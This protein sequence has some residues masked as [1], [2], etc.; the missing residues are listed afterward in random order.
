VAVLPILDPDTDAPD[1]PAAALRLEL[2]TSLV[3]LPGLEV[4]DVDD[5]GAA[6]DVRG[7]SARYVLECGVQRAQGRLRVWALL[8]DTPTVNQIWGERWDGTT[9]DLFELTERVAQDIVRA[10]EVELVIGEPARLYRSLV[11]PASVERIYRGWHQLAK[12]TSTGLLNAIE[13]FETVSVTVPDTA[14]GPALTAFACWYGAMTGLSDDPEA[15]LARA[16]RD[17]ITGVTL[18]DDTGLS[19]MVKAALMLSEGGDLDEALEEARRAQ[20]KRPT[21][22]VTFGIEASLERY[23]GNWQVAVESA[24]RAMSMSPTFSHWYETTLV[25][26]YHMAGQ[27]QQAADIAEGVVAR[28]P[29]AAEALLLLAASQ[30]ALGLHRRAAGTITTFM[31]RCPGVTRADVRRLH[32]FRDP[33][34]MDRWLTQL[35][36]A[37]LP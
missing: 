34:V 11:D 13:L 15:H 28:S 5:R 24:R 2:L 37:G 18:G 27:Y 3:K 32:H 17:A 19:H 31:T 4:I 1:S 33:S 36:A 6:T 20:A 14:T 8:I 12:G 29:N 9:E 21:C 7:R 26:A 16:W 22:D 30:E 23:R 10:L 25:G 35:E